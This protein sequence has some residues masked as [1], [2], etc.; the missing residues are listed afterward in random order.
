M[1]ADRETPAARKRRHGKLF[2]AWEHVPVGC[3]VTVTKD[4][5]TEIETVTAGAAE[6]LGGHTAVIW[7]QGI[8]GCY[9]LD[10]VRLRTISATAEPQS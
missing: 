5:G 2:R 6:L 4:N 9:S 3:P 8:S 1:T 7:L 10:R